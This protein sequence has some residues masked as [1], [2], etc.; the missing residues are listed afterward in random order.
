MRPP[1]SRT[2]LPVQQPINLDLILNLKA[3]QAL[4][5]TIPPPV[6]VQATEVI[7]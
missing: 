2:S 6:L 7:E 3:A 5:L 4:G 1:W